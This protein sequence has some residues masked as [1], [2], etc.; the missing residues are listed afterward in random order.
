MLVLTP[1]V[2][3][4][5]QSS[6]LRQ[7]VVHVEIVTGL[8]DKL[9]STVDDFSTSG[10]PEDNPNANG[11]VLSEH[12]TMV[13]DS[14][15]GLRVKSGQ[16]PPSGRNPLGYIQMLYPAVS[17]SPA[18]PIQNA[19][20]FDISSSNSS[21]EPPGKV[22]FGVSHFQTFRINVGEEAEYSV[23]EIKLKL[24]RV[25]T[26]TPWPFQLMIFDADRYFSA[27]VIPNSDAIA[28]T[29]SISTTT[30]SNSV[31]QE[32]TF[33]LTDFIAVKDKQYV[34]VPRPL[35]E[36]VVPPNDPDGVLWERYVNRDN[37]PRER[38]GNH[39]TFEY[40]SGVPTI[41]T[42][43]NFEYSL[44]VLIPAYSYDGSTA[45]NRKLK[46][47]LGQ[48]PV[49]N[50][51]FEF[52]YTLFGDSRLYFRAWSSATGSFSGEETDIGATD[53]HTLADDGH[54]GTI[55][56]VHDGDLINDLKR[57]YAIEGIFSS[58]SLLHTASIEKMNP[59]FPLTVWEF[60]THAIPSLETYPVLD[61]WVSLPTSLDIKTYIAGPQKF[62]IKISRKGGH[63]DRMIA[64]HY[65]KNSIIKARIGFDPNSIKTKEGMSPLALGRI[66][67]YEADDLSVTFKC[68]D[69]STD[70]DIKVPAE[71]VNSD[72]KPPAADYRGKHFIDVLDDLIF[73]RARYPRRYRH[74][75]S[76]L[77]AKNTLGDKWITNRSVTA[78]DSEDA[79]DLIEEILQD[80]GFFLIRLEDGTIKLVQY[81]RSENAVRTWDDLDVIPGDK[82]EPFLDDSII[83]RVIVQSNYDIGNNKFRRIITGNEVSSQNNHQPG[84]GKFVADKEI[85]TKWI[86]TDEYNGR[87][88]VESIIKRILGHQAYGLA[89]LSVDT[90]F[91]HFD[92]QIG[93]YISLKTKNF[94][95]KGYPF[96]LVQYSEKFMVVSK[97][98]MINQ[99]SIE[100]G[101]LEARDLQKP[102]IPSFTVDNQSGIPT[103]SPAIFT[104]NVDA[105]ASEDP[106]GGSPPN[107]TYEWDFDYNGLFQV[108]ATGITAQHS[109]G[110]G[111]IGF[112]T[113]ALRV[114]YGLLEAII[115]KTVRVVGSPVAEISFVIQSNPGLPNNIIFSGVQSHS[116]TNKIVKME[117]DLNYDTS[118]SP[119]TFTVDVIGERAIINLPYKSFTV[120]LR[121]TDDLGQTDTATLTITG[122]TL[123]PPDVTNFR[124]ERYGDKITLLWDANP[125][126]DALGVEI[127][128]QYEPTESQTFT[129]QS[130]PTVDQLITREEMSTRYTFPVPRPF[131]YWTFL[132]KYRDTSKNY[133]QNAV[134]VFAEI[135]DPKDRNIILTKD[136]IATGWQGNHNQTMI[137][138]ATGAL[139]LAGEETIGDTTTSP[140]STLSGSPIWQIGPAFNSGTFESDI[141]DL[142]ANLSPVRISIQTLT[143]LLGSNASATFEFAISEGLTSPISF[144]AWQS[145]IPTD[146]KFRY[147]KIRVSLAQT[148]DASNIKVTQCLLTIDVPDRREKGED[149]NVPV[150]G[151][152]ITFHQPFNTV[153]AVAWALQQLTVAHFAEIT[154]KTVSGFTVKIRR[155]SD[156]VDVGSGGTRLFDY[157]AEGY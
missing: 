37:Y 145:F 96:Q 44:K 140:I 86:G 33:T 137:E 28:L 34:V 113:V 1:Q 149:I 43:N 24:K 146:L 116:P 111:S 147:L 117:W 7:P 21:I 150:G 69:L 75:S 130:N 143:E 154:D 148:D 84:A 19:V 57:Y 87:Y 29:N 4:E 26:D 105:S 11:Y 67:D 101:L 106:V 81:P 135:Y 77:S 72:R 110:T 50:G 10:S 58:P 9:L 56:H 157:I 78:D 25:G 41:D 14:E 32:I 132:I 122:K 64:S 108:D 121:V 138:A 120:A 76:F 153:P 124:I 102:P 52:Q 51:E 5:I 55:T 68:Q 53:S 71:I 70:F 126:F 109:Y 125:D 144:G 151:L 66:I 80:I 155:V 74:D 112:K 59:K 27:D 152:Q 20:A 13:V 61:D 42:E 36:G 93:D 83:N 133:S 73:N 8:L 127:Q 65:M 141:I 114:K 134:A 119:P 3:K 46:F 15:T 139:M 98:P 115:S 48:T 18:D 131:G 88:L 30:I 129:W 95:R 85:K 2:Q 92:I 118:T 79:K 136:F 128:G 35:P 16:L 39:R 156:G 142:G 38:S 82:Q 99:P 45:N 17:A 107:L 40:V 62:N 23:K 89:R 6:V 100:F 54:D 103:G 49:Q 63:V 22:G 91:R 104:I 94:L 123:A 97:R 47:D 31:F 12:R 90:N 60:T